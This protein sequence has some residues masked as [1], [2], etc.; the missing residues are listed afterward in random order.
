MLPEVAVIGLGRIGL[1]LAISFADRGLNVLGIDK[2]AQRLQAVEAAQMPFQEPGAQDALER[3]RATGRL[4]V[5]DRVADAAAAEH[6]VITL[7]TPSFSHIEIDIGDIRSALD[8]LLGLLRP[9]HA[10]TLR[11]TIAPGTTDFVAGYL[12]KH[13]NFVIGEDVFVAH[14]PERIA[15][16]HFMEEIQS[17]PCIVGGVGEE[18]GERVGALFSVF[19]APIVQTS[20]VQAEL[21]K[22]W[23]NI[24]RYA[25]FALPNLLMMDCEQHGANVFD[26][27]DLINRDYPR[28]GIAMPGLTGGTCLRKDF[29]FSEERSNAPGMLLAVSRV[30]ES[31]PLFLVEGM[32]RRIG[33]LN[34]RK[35]AVL[36]LAFKGN[37]D[38]ER[39]S[40]AYKLVRLLERELAD[41]V[42]HDPR[43]ATPTPP[44]EQVVHDADAIV[45]AANHD[46]FRG[47]EPLRLIAELARAD[48]LIVDPWNCF[49]AAQVFAYVT[50][51]SAITNGRVALQ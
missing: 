8:D 37:T 36:G 39:D 7:G 23:T 6:I 33:S 26:V 22:I 48:A 2:D 40:L 34:G 47:N 3:V 18:S 13:C 21:A 15:A 35:I 43:V 17:L 49:G 25:H 50:E 30:N 51:L 5:S 44:F 16:G 9:G 41:V 29:A 20:P 19:G 1:P 42:A 24:L 4:T 31:V 46:E 28:G 32:K 14:C 38:D 11:S 27:I 45:V 12:A 10:L